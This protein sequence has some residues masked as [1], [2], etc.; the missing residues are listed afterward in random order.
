MH[1]HYHSH[2]NH[3]G[4]LRYCPHCDVVY[5]TSCGKEWGQRQTTWI[6]YGD[7]YIWTYKGIP[8]TVTYDYSGNYNLTTSNGTPVTSRSVISAFNTYNANS[9]SKPDTDGHFVVTNHQHNK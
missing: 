8:Y 4:S 9:S 6:T 2:C 7:P 5:C 1:T 3:N